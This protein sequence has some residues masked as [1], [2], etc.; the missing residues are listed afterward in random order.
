LISSTPSEPKKMKRTF[1][2]MIFF[3][4]LLGFQTIICK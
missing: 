4:W 1:T 2:G 3:I